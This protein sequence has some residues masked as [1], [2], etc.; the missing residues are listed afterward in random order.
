MTN[1]LNCL[2]SDKHVYIFG[3]TLFIFK[4]KLK[5]KDNHQTEQTTIQQTLELINPV[6]KQIMQLKSS[7]SNYE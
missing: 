2:I 1:K 6:D 7:N 4:E 5:N 3:N